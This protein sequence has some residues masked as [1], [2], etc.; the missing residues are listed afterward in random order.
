MLL[1]TVTLCVLR[2]LALI[3]KGR[4]TLPCVASPEEAVV[5]YNLAAA[6]LFPLQVNLLVSKYVR[7][8]T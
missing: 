1:L 2:I 5:T 4:L 3:C 8:T 6:Q 7:S